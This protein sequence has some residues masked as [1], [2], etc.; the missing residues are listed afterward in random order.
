ML[1]AIFHGVQDH[2]KQIIVTEHNSH[3]ISLR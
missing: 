3:Y 2:L 1:P